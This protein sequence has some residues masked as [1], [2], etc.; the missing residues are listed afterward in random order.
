MQIELSWPH[1]DIKLIRLDQIRT[2]SQLSDEHVEKEAT[3]INKLYLIGSQGLLR[4]QWGNIH[5]REA[6]LEDVFEHGEVAIAP[7]NLEAAEAIVSKDRILIVVVT[8][9]L[10][11]IA[12]LECL[13]LLHPRKA[14]L[15]LEFTIDLAVAIHLVRV[16]EHCGSCGG[17]SLLL[18]ILR[19]SRSS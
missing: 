10:V 3:L 7:E 17:S 2:A 16:H 6:I 4:R 12:D 8:F 15:N 5:A 19:Q 9:R 1:E 11:R 13:C 18:I 14:T